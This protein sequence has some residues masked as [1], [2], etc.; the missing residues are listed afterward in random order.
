MSSSFFIGNLY[1]ATNGDDWEEGTY[2]RASSSQ[3]CK[4]SKCKCDV[5]ISR[6]IRGNRQV[7]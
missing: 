3:L 1:E 6:S 4:W 5:Y 7:Q 2:T